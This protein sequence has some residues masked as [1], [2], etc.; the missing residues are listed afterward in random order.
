MAPIVN[1]KREVAYITA[2]PAQAYLLDFLSNS[3]VLL[4][5]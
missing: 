4:H 2:D 5:T 3:N 1:K